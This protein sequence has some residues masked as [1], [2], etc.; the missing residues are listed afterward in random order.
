MKRLF[1]L[2]A[3]ALALSACSEAPQSGNQQTETV[4]ESQ[5]LSESERLNQW[6][7]EK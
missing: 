5:K 2:S 4:A 7:E 1:L 3:V 6:F